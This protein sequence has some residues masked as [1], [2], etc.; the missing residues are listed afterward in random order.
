VILF[1][2]SQVMKLSAHND[3]ELFV[4]NIILT[5]KEDE[6]SELKT[7]M[8]SKGKRHTPLLSIL[9]SLTVNI[10]LKAM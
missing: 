2:T 7:L 8:D 4:K 5:A 1:V 3:S 10:F 9:S 6:L